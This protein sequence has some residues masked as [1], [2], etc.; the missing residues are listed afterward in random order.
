[1]K[2]LF[3]SMTRKVEFFFNIS[4]IAFAPCIMTNEKYKLGSCSSP[5]A[6]MMKHAP[7][8][9]DAILTPKVS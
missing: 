6:D 9:G 2:L 3:S 8:Q 7:D 4:A 1:M 5:R